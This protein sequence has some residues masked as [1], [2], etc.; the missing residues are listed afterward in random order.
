MIGQ[1]LMRFVCFVTTHWDRGDEDEASLRVR[2]SELLAI[3]RSAMDEGAIY[4]RFQGEQ[5]SAI[6]IIQNI[7]RNNQY[8]LPT[9]LQIQ[10]ELVDQKLPLIATEAGQ[11]LLKDHNEM[12]HKAEL[13]I[14]SV[15]AEIKKADQV[16]DNDLI[17]KL[18]S[19]RTKV[20][21]DI[22]R[23][24]LEQESID[25]SNFTRIRN[26]GNEID[27][28]ENIYN[29]LAW[30]SKPPPPY[31][32]KEPQLLQ[33]S[34][35][36]DLTPETPITQHSS[37]QEG[38]IETTLSVLIPLNEVSHNI[39]RW[40]FRKRDELLGRPTVPPAHRRLHWICVRQAT[41]VALI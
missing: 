11:S 26:L 38:I 17:K 32:E 1:E 36:E 28:W 4:W 6:R 10:Q 19:Q 12:Q 23:L 34:K 13:E 24:R 20:L 35:R 9:P 16:H 18:E 21:K 5:D 14:H 7:V 25:S 29:L 39:Q 40:V 41:Y 31:S 27:G 3:W 33:R 8:S 15:A 22:E 37:I 30:N 2:E